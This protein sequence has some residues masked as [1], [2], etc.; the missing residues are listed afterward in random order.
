L[1]KLIPINGPGGGGA[2]LGSSNNPS[3]RVAISADVAEE[4]VEKWKL[5]QEEARYNKKN[6]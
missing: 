3:Y 2:A 5:A 4:K 6:V 1:T